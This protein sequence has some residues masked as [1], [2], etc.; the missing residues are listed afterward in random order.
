MKDT[1]YL[2]YCNM[3]SAEDSNF[4][5]RYYTNMVETGTGAYDNHLHFMQWTGLVGNCRQIL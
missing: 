2:F 5:V 1:Y 4:D 3:L